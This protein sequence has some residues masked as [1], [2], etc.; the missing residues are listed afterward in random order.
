MEK[1]A[2]SFILLYFGL[3]M[4]ACGEGWALPAPS[5]AETKPAPTEIATSLPT[6]LPSP[7]ATTRKDAQ[8]RLIVWG[9]SE[10]PDGECWIW[11]LDPASQSAAIPPVPGEPPCLY[12]VVDVN[13]KQYFAYLPSSHTAFIELPKEIT[14]YDVTD[15]GQLV[16]HQT[17][18][19][20]EIRLSST[21]Q[22]AADGSVYFSGILGSI[23]QLF[24]YDGETETIEPY[25]DVSDGF[26]TDT[27]LSPDNR[28]L[29]YLVVGGY[30]HALV[31]PHL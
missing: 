21:P 2:R 8:E 12:A 5:P 9:I 28:Y 4:S 20:G 23:E 15:D 1:T 19:L 10:W 31:L 3:L 18:A 11:I 25:L 13:G 27:L 17:I 24:R 16:A 30:P 22:W 7:T 6:A 26:P 14:L 29:A